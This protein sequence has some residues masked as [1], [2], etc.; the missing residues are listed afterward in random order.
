MESICKLPGRNLC[1]PGGKVSALFIDLDGTVVECEK[2]FS[3]AR[4]RFG[5]LMELH[6]FDGKEAI[7]A[8]RTMYMKA[9]KDDG[10]R[11]HQ[12]SEAMVAVYKQLCRKHKKRARREVIG[13]CED[14]GQSPFFRDPELFDDAAQVINRSRHNFLIIAVTM[15]DRAVQ[16]YKVREAGLDSAFDHYIVTAY[17]NKVERVRELIEDLNI[18]PHT[19]AFIGNSVKSDGQCL[20]ETNFIHVPFEPGVFD[21]E[22]E[23]VSTNGFEVFKV[24]DW[25]DAEERAIQRLTMRRDLALE[26]EKAA[27]ANAGCKSCKAHATR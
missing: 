26:R 23:L 2:Y 27:G 11:R 16:K 15:G 5:Y 4:A 3:A 20:S 19:S 17:D 22:T 7:E 13:M 9:M 12:M 14:I 21:S 1:A 10:V 18:D 8:A 6:G 24:R 25:R